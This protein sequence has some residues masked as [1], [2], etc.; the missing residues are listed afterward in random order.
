MV[1]IYI[2]QF[3]IC[4]QTYNDLKKKMPNINFDDLD[5]FEIEDTTIGAQEFAC[6]GGSCE[7]I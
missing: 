4:R 3:N 1:N 5:K 2:F 6:A 7:L